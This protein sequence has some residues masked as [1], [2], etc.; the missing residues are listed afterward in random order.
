M[1]AMEE[2]GV[3]FPQAP[4]CDLF[5][6]TAGE[7]ANIAALEIAANL[8]SEGF[9]VLT[10]TVGRSIKAQMKLA[11]KL[12]AKYT[13]VIGD[14][15]LASGALSVKNMETKETFDVDIDDF[16]DNFADI[17]VKGAVAGLANLDF[18]G[19]TQEDINNYF[20]FK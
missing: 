17:V 14:N 6:V 9:F 5:I 18:T 8:R 4:K 20:N 16:S 2:S 13:V 10:D 15:E 3:S 1:L 11:N 7:E 12:G 19:M